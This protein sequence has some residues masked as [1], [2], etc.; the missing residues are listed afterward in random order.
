MSRLWS[1]VP[2]VVVLTVLVGVA[3]WGHHSGW[4]LPQ[5]SALVGSDA[6]DAE[7][8]CDEH[9]V[10][11][12][13]CI[14]CNAD[15]VPLETTFG[16]CA[17]HG[18]AQCPLENP[19]V[20]QIRSPPTITEADF[21]RAANA[22]AVRPR[23]ENNSNCLLHAKRIQFASLASM[24]KAGVD[25]AI[26]NKRPI[27]EVIVANGEVLYDETVTAHLASRV[28]GTVW[29]VEKQVGDR[30]EKGDVLALIDAADVGRAKAEL[31][32]AISGLRLARINAERLQ[33]L[34][35][36]GSVA[37]RQLREAESALQEAQIRLLSAQQ[38]LV[39][40]GL[41]V[42]A[43]DFAERSTDEIAERIQFLGLPAQIVAELDPES[44][45]SN[46]FPLRAPLESVVVARDVV[47]GEVVNTSTTIFKLSDVRQLWLILDVRQ[48]DATYL[49]LGQPVRFRPS[50]ADE[51]NEVEGSL[52]WISTEADDQTRTVKVRVN[53]PNADGRL[54]AN[55]FGRGRIVLREEPAATVVPTEAVHWDGCCHVVFVRDRNFL[56]EETPKFFHIR[57]V[58]LGVKQGDMTEIIAGLLPGEVIASQNSVVLESQLLKGNLGAGCAHG[59][60]H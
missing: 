22:L 16:W 20:A 45:T 34:A 25:I 33:P 41:K 23:S 50:G 58:R 15:L 30:V 1:A 14:E 17:A 28:A 19:E 7:V 39:N 57:K 12:L 60:A 51:A 55:T 4:T 48:D 26:V 27:V 5:F 21:E 37:G 32:K 3:A 11:E 2:T 46:L 56:K 40:L 13:S 31:L 29:R 10:A 9:N 6:A 47:P 54:R 18:V 42:R 52:A 24:E 8:W 44:A 59:H 53:L 36:S 35:E 43:N 38:V 49:A